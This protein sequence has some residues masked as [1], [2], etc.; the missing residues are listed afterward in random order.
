L[1]KFV[2]HINNQEDKQVTQKLYRWKN[3]SYSVTD[4]FLIFRTLGSHLYCINMTWKMLLEM[5]LLK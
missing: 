2:F 1:K 3:I 5:E 4:G